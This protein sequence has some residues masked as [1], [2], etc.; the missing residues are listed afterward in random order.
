MTNIEKV[1]ALS[2]DRKHTSYKCVPINYVLNVCLHQ[3]I[4]IRLS[5]IDQPSDVRT[6]D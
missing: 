1:R 3:Y 4:S 5:Y 2:V 6:V